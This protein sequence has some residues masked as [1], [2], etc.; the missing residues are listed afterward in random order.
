MHKNV[1][2]CIYNHCIEHNE[3]LT[4]TMVTITVEIVHRDS[5][6]KIF[7]CFLDGIYFVEK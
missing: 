6:T 3:P 5:L 4:F 7:A 1:T 2:T